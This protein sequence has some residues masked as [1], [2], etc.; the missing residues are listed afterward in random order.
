MRIISKENEN[1][2]TLADFTE[3]VKENFRE[4]YGDD[5]CISGS[6]IL[7]N[8]STR[9]EGVTVRREEECVAP[10]I[11]M[12]AYHKRFLCGESFEN[13]L[14]EMH[15]CIE[16]G[17]DNVP[18]NPE[19]LEQDMEKLKKLIVFRLINREMNEELLQNVPYRK[20]Q[21]LAVTYHIYVKVSP[22]NAGSILINLEYMERLGLTEKELYRLAKA[23]TPR[24]FPLEINPMGEMIK[25]LSQIN[26]TEFPDELAE[27]NGY[28]MYIISNRTCFNGASC[29]LYPGI[30][31]ELADR[32][33][34][35]FYILPSSIHELIVVP[36]D[37]EPDELLQMVGNVNM[38]QVPPEDILSNNI[39]RY[40]PEDDALKLICA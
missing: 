38:T 11:Y 28:P 35:G 7:K 5:F 17:F 1:Y 12:N 10:T 16:N 36:A 8:N 4:Y 14:S 30:R 37:R 27:L 24:H 32:L 15:E 19:I 20:F 40:Y 2:L 39:Y 31:R 29:L 22:E 34:D 21:D 18:E 33:P 9:L 23:N 25:K 6:S 26:D 13:L 3:A